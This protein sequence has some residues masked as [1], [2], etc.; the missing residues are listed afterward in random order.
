MNL[1]DFQ[2]RIGYFFHDIDLL[3]EALTH[4]SFNDRNAKKN[5]QRL[6][7]FGDKVLGLVICQKLMHEFPEDSE[8]ELSKRFSHGVSCENLSQ[9]ALDLQIDKM[10]KL[11]KGELLS[12]GNLNKN[13]LEDALEAIIGAIYSDSGLE[14]AEKFITDH[15]A[16][17]FDPQVPAPTDPVSEFQE[18]VQKQTKSLPAI[19]VARV[20]GGDHNPIFE[21][22]I[23][24]QA[25][26]I[27]EVG[28]GNSKKEAVKNTC[29]KALESYKK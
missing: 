23:I 14:A 25:M 9:V 7:F 11:G 29:I 5:Y 3:E 13:N 6:E 28:H 12:G 21:A 24:V 18:L 2:E 16:E 15:F 26:N 1:Q 17:I 20:S 27:E 8:G 4:P 19:E 10:I 22:K